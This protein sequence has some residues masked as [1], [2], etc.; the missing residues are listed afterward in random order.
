MVPGRQ[1]F[2]V[3]FA[4]FSTK[5]RLS[6]VALITGLLLLAPMSLASDR[7]HAA[8]SGDQWTVF[9]AV[10][11]VR[12]RSDGDT[13]IWRQVERGQT[14]VGTYAIATGPVG[15]AT[16]THG[17][18]V[19]H[20]APN[21]RVEVLAPSA[22]DIESQVVQSRGTLF[23][24]VE[25]RR[26]HGFRIETPYLVTRV[27]GATFSVTV[28]DL[29]ADVAVADGAVRIAAAE[30]RR[31]YTVTAGRLATV[32][33]YNRRAVAVGQIAP[34]GYAPTPTAPRQPAT[35]V[36]LAPIG[37]V[38]DFAPLTTSAGPVDP[39]SM[40]PL[41]PPLGRILRPN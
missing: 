23:Y 9:Q 28:T 36:E 27:N 16:L 30:G 33:A 39:P 24:G 32:T 7:A 21:S 20:L 37:G 34:G 11:D 22:G 5:T 10:G 1:M 40:S 25:T 8:E 31:S 41:L 17:D 26:N 4:G 2:A 12:L 13:A 3:A 6:R 38:G 18:D 15:Q 14:L 29:G 35:A 19:I